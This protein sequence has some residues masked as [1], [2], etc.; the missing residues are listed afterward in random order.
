MSN[1]KVAPKHIWLNIDTLSLD[2]SLPNI[3]LSI[4]EEKPKHDKPITIFKKPTK[5]NSN[6]LF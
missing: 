1:Q 2:T 5:S 4:E 3:G 6:S